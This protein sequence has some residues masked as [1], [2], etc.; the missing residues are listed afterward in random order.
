[1]HSGTFSGKS[2]TMFTLNQGLLARCVEAVKEGEALARKSGQIQCFEI[3]R[4]GH[5]MNLVLGRIMIVP[6]TVCNDK[7]DFPVSLLYGALVKQIRPEDLADLMVAQIGD[8]EFDE[9]SEA[10]M[11]EIKEKLFQVPGTKKYACLVVFV[12]SWYTPREYVMFKYTKDS[13]ALANALRHLVFAAYFDPRLS[14]AFDAV[15]QDID[16]VNHGTELDVTNITPKLPFGEVAENVVQYY[17]D[18]KSGDDTLASQERP[19]GPD[20]PKSKKASAYKMKIALTLDNAK[21]VTEMLSSDEVDV[22]SAVTEAAEAAILNK[23]ETPA[24][25]AADDNAA[26]K[27]SLAETGLRRR[28]DYNGFI[29]SSYACPFCKHTEASEEAIDSHKNRA[30]KS[31]NSGHKMMEWCSGTPMEHE[32]HKRCPG[33]VDGVHCDCKCHE[34]AK[35]EG[36]V[37]PS[38]LTASK[39]ANLP[40]F[41]DLSPEEEMKFREWARINNPP[42]INKWDMY[43]PVVRQEWEKRGIKPH[44]SKQLGLPTQASKTAKE[45]GPGEMKIKLKLDLSDAMGESLAAMV[46]E[47]ASHAMADD[48]KEKTDKKKEKKEKKAAMGMPCEC[49]DPGCPKHRGSDRCGDPAVGIAYRIDME[50]RTGTPMCEDCLM[51][52]D[53]SGVFRIEP[54]EQEVQADE[55]E[56]VS[57]AEKTADTADNAANEKGGEGAIEVKTDADIKNTRGEEPELAPD[58]NAS[59]KTADWNVYLDGKLVLVATAKVTASA[60][61]VRDKL[62]AHGLDSHIRVARG[63]HKP[64]CE[65]GFCKNKGKLPGTK[66][67]DEDKEDKKEASV[68]HADDVDAGIVAAIEHQLS[69]DGRT[70]VSLEDMISQHSKESRDEHEAKIAQFR[71]TVVA[72]ESDDILADVLQPFTTLDTEQPVKDGDSRPELSKNEQKTHS[73]APKPVEKAAKTAEA[74]ETHHVEECALTIP[75]D[76]GETGAYTMDSEGKDPVSKAKAD[77]PGDSKPVDPIEL[78]KQAAIWLGEEVEEPLHITANM[79][80]KCPG[81]GGQAAK[82]S[83][84]APY[85][86]P[87]CGWKSQ[88]AAGLRKRASERII[89]TLDDLLHSEPFDPENEDHPDSSLMEGLVSGPLQGGTHETNQTAGPQ[90]KVAEGEIQSDAE[91]I[92]NKKTDDRFSF[93]GPT[94]Q[95]EHPNTDAIREQISTSQEM[96]KHE[97]IEE[98]ESEVHAEA[99]KEKAELFSEEKEAPTAEIVEAPAGSGKIVI[100]INAKWLQAHGITGEEQLGEPEGVEVYDNGGETVD[101]YTIVLRNQPVEPVTIEGH[102]Y[103]GGGYFGYGMGDDIGPG[104]YFQFIDGVEP[105]PQLGHLISFHDLPE[106]NQR[107]LMQEI[108]ETGELKE[109]SSAEGDYQA[110]PVTS[111]MSNGNFGGNGATGSMGAPDL[112]KHSNEIAITADRLGEIQRQGIEEMAGHAADVAVDILPALLADDKTAAKKT[113]DYEGWSNWETWHVALLIDNEQQSHTTKTNLTRNAIKKGLGAE[114]LA[115]QFSRFFAPQEKATREFYEDNAAN[116]REERGTY[117]RQQLE[118]TKPEPTGDRAKD[119]AHELF[120]ATFYG[121]GGVSSWEQPYEPPNWLEIAEHALDNEGYEMRAE[122][123][124]KMNLTPADKEMLKGMNITTSKKASAAKEAGFNFWFPGQVLREFY[125]EIQH[126]LVD[127]PNADNHPMIQDVDL[128]P[129]KV[130][131]EEKEACPC[132][133]EG[134]SEPTPEEVAEVAEGAPS[135]RSKLFEERLREREEREMSMEGNIKEAGTPNY[136]STDPGA[137]GIGRD[138]KPQV[139]EG[140]PLRKEWDIRGPMFSDE[141]YANYPGVPGQYLASQKTA[142]TGKEDQKELLSDF[143]KKVMGEI[144][145][146]FAAAFKVTS[147]PVQLDRVPGTGEV[148]LVNVEN[149]VNNWPFYAGEVGGRVKYLL[150]EMNDSDIQDA[151]NDAWAQ[152]A[153]W[154]NGSGSGNFTYE[155][156]VRAESIDTDAMTLRYKFVTGTKGE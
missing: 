117:E 23:R 99:E 156:F 4:N 80:M 43:H 147:R 74:V 141:F 120:G 36:V 110:E 137:V 72:D 64:G 9:Y 65:C 18:L 62:V 109:S 82:N 136:V 66:D 155:V 11:Q 60:D 93:G 53:N 78:E 33:V 31:A 52:A 129:E 151:I 26:K 97:T 148:N 17:P 59:V 134:A 61:E 39:I 152:A 28:R 76:G 5:R 153:V 79:T 20:K 13:G 102:T 135:A 104:G 67:K 71:R 128:A 16:T 88:K 19:T 55:W 126:E 21:E 114:H 32:D 75:E 3:F 27:A 51:D 41:R 101:R 85:V 116:A 29:T 34:K 40:I 57:S 121:M 111:G 47:A 48:A 118:G 24:D 1:M 132:D 92:P 98:K 77:I 14:S 130:G 45:D 123:P 127:Y 46:S 84:E 30:H 107:R 87:K 146:T 90:N 69:G 125:P 2:Y 149:S 42:D 86:C 25:V 37:P 54:L 122:N 142:A 108:S 68:K 89:A 8:S 113:A 133:H 106:A 10:D 154:H 112:A 44:D 35:A 105:G 6:P 81:C 7:E 115:K 131:G 22:I 83:H 58:K 56:H 49:G 38:N 103:P 70:N 138:G 96:D 94:N 139:L 100:N 91:V 150:E 73:D 143:L 12:P 63:A 15:L 50:D 124:E 140:A 119:L 145:V 144:A 95:S